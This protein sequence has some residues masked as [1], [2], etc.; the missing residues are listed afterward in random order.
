[1]R[2]PTIS[3]STARQALAELDAGRTFDLYAETVWAGAGAELDM[4]R[5]DR[6]AIRLEQLRSESDS[7][8]D[9]G[10]ISRHDFDRRAAEAIHGHLPRN[11]ELTSS[12][13]FW[14]WLAVAKLRDVVLWRF[15]PK[16]AEG[17]ASV[18]LQNFGIGQ[19]ARQ[20]CENFPYKL[21]IRAELAFDS[22]HS[23]PY[24]FARRGDV[25]FWTSHIHR[26]GYSSYRELGAALIRF[27]YPDELAGEPRLHPGE[28]TEQ[29]RG[30]RTLA[31]R[32]KRLQA[33]VEFAYLQPDE[34]YVLVCEQARGLSLNLGATPYHP[35]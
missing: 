32:L 33:N 19:S 3:V 2:Y 25:D 6:L 26:Q 8:A 29:K 34:M 18:N 14:T 7:L 10:K 9:G 22:G 31:K 16:A 13:D 15:P 4:Q 5:I 21:W 11:A 28:E 35:S 12:M 1:M 30:I 20:R 24:R 23:D 27:Q 17:D